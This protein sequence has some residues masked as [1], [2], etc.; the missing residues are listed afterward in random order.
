MRTT[1]TEI[2]RQWLAVL[3]EIRFGRVKNRPN[4]N[5]FQRERGRSGATSLVGGDDRVGAGLKD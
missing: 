5:T 1:P 3:T 2:V 4:R